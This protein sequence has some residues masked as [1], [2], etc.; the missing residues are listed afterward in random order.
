MGNR[1]AQN[2]QAVMGAGTF[3][4]GS[5]QIVSD[6]DGR[7]RGGR[8]EQRQQ[9]QTGPDEK[10]TDLTELVEEPNQPLGIILGNL[11]ENTDSLNLVAGYSRAAERR[12]PD[13]GDPSGNQKVAGP[14]PFRPAL[15]R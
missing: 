2:S 14:Y 4:T 5:C 13:Q 12:K 9:Y 15:Q 8:D 7:I 3:V 11:R 10:S 1:P 6:I